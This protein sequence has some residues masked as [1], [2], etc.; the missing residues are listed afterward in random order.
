M[1]DDTRGAARDAIA[2]VKACLEQALNYVD[3]YPDNV[4]ALESVVV[5]CRSVIT[6]LEC[7][8]EE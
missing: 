2:E 4:L 3:H 6:L 7:P 1:D 8:V 5:L